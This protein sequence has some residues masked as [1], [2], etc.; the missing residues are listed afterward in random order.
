MTCSSA[1]P[2]PTAYTRAGSQSFS[3]RAQFKTFTATVELLVGPKAVRFLV[4]RELLTHHSPFFAAALNG[5][6][7]EG[8][9]QSIKLREEPLDVFEL[10][11]CWLYT[12]TLDPIFFK[13][14]KPAYY[15]LLNVYALADRLAVERLRNHTIDQIAELAEQ[16][17][18]VPT[19]SDTHILYETIRDSAPLRSLVLDLF[20]FKKTDKLLA[21]HPDDWHPSFLR[22]LAVLLKRPSEAAMLRHSFRPWQAAWPPLARG[23]EGCGRVIDTGGQNA[24]TCVGCSRPFCQPCALLGKGRAEWE[25]GEEVCRPWKG[26]RCR[27][28]HEHAETEKCGVSALG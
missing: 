9:S 22:D 5:S 12:S 15:T 6:F 27:L 1:I 7:A 20:A 23:C 28:Y 2:L 26:A 17:N 16:T 11:I 19:P 18:C 8:L 24:R 4:H 25:A 21:E 10:F 13:D 3:L 14:G